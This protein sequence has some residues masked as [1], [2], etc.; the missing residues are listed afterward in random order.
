MADTPPTQTAR[1]SFMPRCVIPTESGVVAAVPLHC[2]Q[3]ICADATHG[4]PHPPSSTIRHNTPT[5]LGDNER[6]YTD[7]RPLMAKLMT[8][9]AVHPSRANC[10]IDGHILRM[11]HE[12]PPQSPLVLGLCESSILTQDI[13]AV[14]AV[15]NTH[16][17]EGFLVEHVPKDSD[18][19]AGHPAGVDGYIT[20]PSMA[21]LACYAAW[22]THAAVIGCGYGEMVTLFALSGR[23]SCIGFE[24]FT[25]RKY[26]ARSVTGTAGVFDQTPLFD[27]L[28]TFENRWPDDPTLIWTNNY[29]FND[30]PSSNIPKDLLG[31]RHFPTDTSVLVCMVPFTGEAEVP[32]CTCGNCY[33]GFCDHRGLPGCYIV[34]RLD[35]VHTP[36]FCGPRLGFLSGNRVM[37]RLPST[38]VRLEPHGAGTGTFDAC[39]YQLFTCTE[40]P[41]TPHAGIAYDKIILTAPS[42]INSNLLSQLDFVAQSDVVGGP[43]M[44]HSLLFHGV[45]G[46][47]YG[48]DA[49]VVFTAQ[50]PGAEPIV[51]A[52]R[53]LARIRDCRMPGVVRINHDVVRST[54]QGR[55]FINQVNL[56]TAQVIRSHFTD[57]TTLVLEPDRDIGYHQNYKSHGFL[58]RLQQALVCSE[59]RSDGVSPKSFADYRCQIDLCPLRYP[60]VWIELPD[61]AGPGGAGGPVASVQGAAAHKRRRRGARV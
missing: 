48:I 21:R 33:E 56:I 60:T 58:W 18:A 11:T 20:I 43:L 7:D 51:F 29:R 15:C 5:W 54:M 49:A 30:D 28:S 12:V 27:A 9:H 35:H 32:V 44:E 52:Y 42:D 14:L 22:C 36:E 13:P 40:T 2:D 19:V 23:R 6:L 55:S 47:E 17:C 31:L 39:A 46:E 61:P 57:A 10:T 59:S 34:R 53:T 25:D 26:I 37:I 16:V 4:H 45:D 41:P 3:V 1:L 24:M 8:S 38:G 50:E